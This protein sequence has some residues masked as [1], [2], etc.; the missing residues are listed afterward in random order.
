MQNQITHFIESRRLFLIYV[1]LKNNQ[2]W[3]QKGPRNLTG[4]QCQIRPVAFVDFERFEI[5]SIKQNSRKSKIYGSF[6]V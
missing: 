1:Q 2:L 5:L 3:I 4:I 6:D